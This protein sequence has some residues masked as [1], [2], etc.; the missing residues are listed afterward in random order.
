MRAARISCFVA[1]A[2]IVAASTILRAAESLRVT[3]IVR[4]DQVLVTIELAEVYTDAVRDAIASGL[5]TTFT[6]E[7]ELR[8]AAPRIWVIPAWMDRTI[9]TSGRQRE[10]S[11]RQPHAAPHAHA[12]DRRPRR[13][14]DR[15]ERRRSR[16]TVAH[17][18]EPP[19]AVRYVEAGSDPRLLRTRHRAHAVARIALRLGQEHHSADEVY[20]RALTRNRMTT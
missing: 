15:H 9:V 17:D 4:D 8:T 12:D 19:A 2:F 5:T 11:R 7:L 10:R 13:F 14:G 18:V 1:I 3:P 16:E 6:Y 20:V